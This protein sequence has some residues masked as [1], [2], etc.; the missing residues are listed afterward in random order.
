VVIEAGAPKDI[1]DA[2]IGWVLALSA[3]SAPFVTKTT[4]DPTKIAIPDPT[5]GMFVVYLIPAD[6]SGVT[7]FS[8]SPP[9]VTL[10]HEAR[11]NIDGVQEVV[12]AGPITITASDTVGLV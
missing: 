11:V 9:T 3:D 8:G 5:G 2:S 6:T 7:G 4:A 1:S 12:F 10:Y